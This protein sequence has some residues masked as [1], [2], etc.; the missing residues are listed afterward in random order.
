MLG[1]FFFFPFI[2][3]LSIRIVGFFLLF[4]VQY[5]KISLNLLIS[6]FPSFIQKLE[7]DSCFCLD[8]SSLLRFP[9][10]YLSQENI[11]TYEHHP[12]SITKI[13]SRHESMRHWE[14]NNTYLPTD[15]EKKTDN[16][17]MPTTATLSDYS[18]YTRPI[19]EVN[20]T[21]SP[22]MMYSISFSGLTRTWRKR[23]RNRSGILIVKGRLV[24][25]RRSGFGLVFFIRRLGRMGGFMSSIYHPLPLFSFAFLPLRGSC[26]PRT[27]TP[28]KKKRNLTSTKN[29]LDGTHTTSSPSPASPTQTPPSPA[30]NH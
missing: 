23:S 19:T 17:S 28:K 15:A 27:L 16:F 12:L 18:A 13:P 30:P 26:V 9:F 5:K 2:F 4:F 1:M 3:I 29:T 24:R 7:K 22:R 21:S 8:L 10:Q 6:L 14:K 11:T 20:P 25:G